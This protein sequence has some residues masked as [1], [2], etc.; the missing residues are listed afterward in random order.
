MVDNAKKDIPFE[1]S[2]NGVYRSVRYLHCIDIYAD[3]NGW[4]NESKELKKK[5]RYSAIK[6]YLE[7]ELHPIYR[8]RNNRY[9]VYDGDYLWKHFFLADPYLA[10]RIQHMGFTSL[11]QLQWYAN[12]AANRE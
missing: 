3:E 8:K 6:Q 4:I 5:Y 10:Q 9:D 1:I 2:A 12:K 11:A 7:V